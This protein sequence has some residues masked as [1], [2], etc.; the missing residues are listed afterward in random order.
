MG[1][2]HRPL[3]AWYGDLD[4]MPHIRDFIARGA[5]DAVVSYGEPVAADAAADRKAMA[6]SLED[7]VRALATATLRGRPRPAH[8]AA[9]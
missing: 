8:A 4:F 1:R 6:K 7:A 9:S 3:V 2:Q 5:V